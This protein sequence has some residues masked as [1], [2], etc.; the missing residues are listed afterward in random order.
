MFSFVSF[1]A[2]NYAMRLRC[3]GTRIRERENHN[4]EYFHEAHSKWASWNNREGDG[5]GSGRGSRDK[6]IK[7]RRRS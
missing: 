2:N 3:S 5:K 1:R 4:W 7:L 6:S